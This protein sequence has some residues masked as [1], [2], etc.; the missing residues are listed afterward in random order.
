VSELLLNVLLGG[1]VEGNRL[2]LRSI[3]VGQKVEAEADLG[4]QISNGENADLLGKTQS[5]SAL[6]SDNPDDGVDNPHKDG[7]PGQALE[8][9]SAISLSVVEALE[10]EHEDDDQEDQSS[11]PPHVLVGG[12]GEGSNEAADDV[13]DHVANQRDDGGGVRL[14]EESQVSE[15]ERSSDNPVKV[16]SPEDDTGSG[17]GGLVLDTETSPLG[18]VGA[19]RNSSDEEGEDVHHCV[20]LA[21]DTHVEEHNGSDEHA[22]ESDEEKVPDGVGV[23]IREGD[24]GLRCGGSLFGLLLSAL[25]C[26]CSRQHVLN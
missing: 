26:A 5:S 19:S 3:N 18:I 2:R 14:G 21:G 22:Q 8:S 4:N 24:G 16:A 17:V 13:E 15:D 10:E 25:E 1:L 11:D 20:D 23:V 6:R 12:D 9:I 7:E